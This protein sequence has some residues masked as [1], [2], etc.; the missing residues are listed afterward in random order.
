[1]NA[2]LA[3]STSLSKNAHASDVGAIAA[4]LRADTA[5]G[6]TTTEAEKRLSALGSSEISNANKGRWKQYLWGQV[7]SIVVWLL[8]VAA[9]AAWLTDSRLEAYSILVVLFLNGVIGFAIEW[10]AGKALD[11][12]KRSTKT[13]ARVRRDGNE[14]IVEA[15]Q[16]VPGDLVLVSA[17]DR[18]PGDLRIAESVNL[19][20]DEST[21]TGESVPV[22][23]SVDPLPELTPLAERT[24]MLYLGST[25][26]AGHCTALVT[27]TGTETEIG[28]IGKLISEADHIQTP[29]EKRL[30]D[31]GR[32]L[33]YVVIGIAAIVMFA[34]IARGDEFFLMLEV[35][36]S[37]A[38]AAVPEGLPAVTT[39]ILALG[40]LRMAKR[41]AIV[42][43]LSAVETLG[44]STVIC[45]D[46]TGTLTTNR[47]TV[48]ELHLPGIGQIKPKDFKQLKKSQFNQ[49]RQ[50]LEIGVLCSEASESVDPDGSIK[51]I[52]DP[53]ETALLEAARIFELSPKQIRERN[54]II[55]EEPF[56]AAKKRMKVV[57][58]DSD[59]KR[60]A[61]L[62]GAP[63]VILERSISFVN[64]T[65]EVEVLT[66]EKTEELLHVNREMA[67]RALRLLGFAIKNLDSEGDPSA[68]TD[69]GYTF[70]GFSGIKD[71]IRDGALE[72][73][74][75]A[76]NAGIRVVMLTGDQMETAK[77]I[78]HELKLSGSLDIEAVHSSELTTADEARVYELA[79]DA[80]VFAR[81][82]PEDKLRIVR[83]LQHA[84]EIVAVTGDGV[85]DAPALRQADIG[86]AM[87]MRG[88]EVA[89]EASDVVLTDDNFSTIVDA[90]RGGRAIYANI[91]KFVHLMFSQNL[92]EVLVI[93]AA[94][95]AG[96]PLPLLPLQILWINLVTD[97]FPALALCVEPASPRSMKRKPIKPG[98]SMLSRDFLFTVVWQGLVLSAIAL[99]AYL[100]AL[101][102]YGEG[103]HSQTIAMLAIVGVQL[104]HLFN[105][106]SRTRSAFNRFF[107]NPY[108][109]AAAGIVIL[110]QILAVT[111]SPLAAVLNTVEIGFNDTIVVAITVLLPIVIVE[112]AKLSARILKNR[113]L[114]RTQ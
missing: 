21:L 38:V 31:L 88:T 83:A 34:G 40:V 70:L 82:S 51:G 113:K 15:A 98:E 86:V 43:K 27:A 53:T 63:A 32:R 16:L 23:K 80:D 11:A 85:N 65:G 105:C 22:P 93:F 18:V 96:L 26:V 3:E 42:R 69:N 30:A 90:I 67:G 50:I 33:V 110:L 55:L 104:G 39:L 99:G 95:L 9:L 64:E 71:P 7:A 114:V 81:V 87:G 76:R 29:L 37:L 24:S 107:S 35:A 8:A 36:I 84:N 109:F 102:E 4:D 14:K 108:I 103:S 100:W 2:G 49:S 72:A 78:A 48:Q 28:K 94:I 25:V 60:T 97:V 56:E 73:V 59:N 66:A 19:V 106:R 6:L 58:E 57:V 17:G 46:K 13:L 47:M 75:T 5:T 20:A 92:S 68:D 74:Q 61:L 52:G 89:K 77:A 112:I 101:S 54:T 1:M 44:S 79:R 91:R 111:F 12:L 45:S 41:N 62:K 10:R